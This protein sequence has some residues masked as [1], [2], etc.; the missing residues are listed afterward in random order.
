M[1]PAEVNALSDELRAFT[2]RA[3]QQLQDEQDAILASWPK[4]SADAR[5]K[6]LADL[7][8]TAARLTSQ[9]DELALALAT[10]GLHTAYTLGA[11]AG[12]SAQ[13][14]TAD[15]DALGV[16]AQDLYD[17]VLAATRGVN[18]STKLLI[19]TLARQHVG[20]RLLGGQTATQAATALRKELEGKGIT[21]VTYRDGSRQGLAGYTEM[22][23]RTQTALAYN[24]GTLNAARRTGI[25]FMEVFDGFGC[26]WEGHDDSDKAN[27]TVRPVEECAQAPTSH[28]R[29]TRAFGPR[30]DVTDDQGAVDAARS[31]TAGQVED[32]RQ[33]AIV[34][35]A[36]VEARARRLAA[37]RQKIDAR[38]GV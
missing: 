28:P 29:C 27:G 20:D 7:Q 13:F 17:A 37:R 6:R 36:R 26:G 2:Q 23:A 22:L 35:Q 14:T 5:R 19:R 4:A 32:Q 10:T 3:W 18:N 30:P 9:V 31:Q 34:R 12:G 21:S 38:S 33:V 8:T 25:S 15:V 1:Q 24:H 11:A 16:L